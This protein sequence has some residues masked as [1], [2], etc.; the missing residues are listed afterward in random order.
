MQKTNLI[1]TCVEDDCS[2][3]EQFQYQSED[4]LRGSINQFILELKQ[5]LPQHWL[6]RFDFAQ[7]RPLINLPNTWYVPVKGIV[8]KAFSHT[9]YPFWC[10]IIE[11]EKFQ[12]L[13]ERQTKYKFE[14]E[15]ICNRS[16]FYKCYA[17]LT[18]G[19]ITV[20][21]YWSYFNCNIDS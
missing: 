17:I 3:P 19:E 10:S 12:E 2:Q 4:Q 7:L 16:D 18:R 13:F 14:S 1:H 21:F 9:E 20:G 11:L 15:W 8:N 5:D 6:Q